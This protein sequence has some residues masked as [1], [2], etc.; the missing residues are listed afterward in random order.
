LDEE[1]KKDEKMSYINNMYETLEDPVETPS[2]R[3]SSI[4]I[5][6]EGIRFEVS[7]DRT[8]RVALTEM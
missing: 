5:D 8:Q 4:K 7:H 6:L 2:S 1:I 3:L